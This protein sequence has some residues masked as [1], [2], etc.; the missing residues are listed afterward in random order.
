MLARPALVPVDEAGMAPE[1]WSARIL[2]S[3]NHHGAFATAPAAY[4]HDP[5]HPG[6]ANTLCPSTLEQL[7]TTYQLPDF[8]EALAAYRTRPDASPWMFSSAAA[9]THEDVP[10]DGVEMRLL[11]AFLRLCA[12]RV[13]KALQVKLAP[14]LFLRGLRLMPEWPHDARLCQQ[15][16]VEALPP[17]ML[18]QV[19]VAIIP[20]V[21]TT[22][23]PLLYPRARSQTTQHV[24][25]FVDSRERWGDRTMSISQEEWSMPNFS[26]VVRTQQIADM[27]EE[28]FFPTPES[29]GTGV[30]LRN[31]I[32]NRLTYPAPEIAAPDPPF[33]VD[34]FSAP[35]LVLSRETGPAAAASRQQLHA[36][37]FGESAALAPSLKS[38]RRKKPAGG[39]R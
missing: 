12:V 9:S 33:A 36:A 37:M 19:A 22:N 7:A 11:P 30:V 16:G 32:M 5:T 15:L 35:A 14:H 38:L 20:A 27:E 25:L 23:N 10:Q 8:T 2:S 1:Q 31:R 34:G 17:K 39:R 13:L 26:A 29:E 18:P 21:Q 24:S 6:K 28:Q 3:T 4:R